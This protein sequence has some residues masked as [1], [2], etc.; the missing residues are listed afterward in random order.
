MA[1][2]PEPKL[3]ESVLVYWMPGRILL[4]PWHWPIHAW[5]VHYSPPTNSRLA[6]CVVVCVLCVHCGLVHI[7]AKGVG[8]EGLEEETVEGC[9]LR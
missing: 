4:L 8:G 9:G 1:S 6:V 7:K 5:Q 2:G 3:I